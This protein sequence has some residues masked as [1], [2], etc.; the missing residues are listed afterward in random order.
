MPSFSSLCKLRENGRLADITPTMLKILGLTQQ[1]E[2][3]RE[4]M[5]V[6]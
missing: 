4:S 1:A 5:I 3:T 2:M 6:D